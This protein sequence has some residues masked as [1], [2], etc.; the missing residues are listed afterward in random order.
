MF[1]FHIKDIAMIFP[2]W[3]LSSVWNIYKY[4]NYFALIDWYWLN[5]LVF[6]LICF[7]LGP[8]LCLGLI[9]DSDLKVRVCQGPDKYLLTLLYLFSTVKPHLCIL[10][11]Y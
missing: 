10:F 2:T 11:I 9:S 8:D 4:I 6:F 7:C 1:L 5:S 3:K